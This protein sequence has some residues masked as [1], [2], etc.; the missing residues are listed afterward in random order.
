MTPDDRPK[1]FGIGLVSLDLVVSLQP[2]ALIRSWTGGTCGNILSI[3]AFL[4]WEAYPIARMNDDPASKRVRADLTRWGVRLDFSQCSP[5]S[6]TPIIVQEIQKRSDGSPTHRFHWVCQSCGRRL[7]RFRAVT[8]N[9]IEAVVPALGNASVFF[10]DRL[11]RSAITLAEIASNEGAV[12]VFE[13]SGATTAE[14]FLEALRIAHVVKY[15]EQ[16]ISN[17]P[18]ISENKNSNLVEIQT[19]GAKGLRYRH[20]FGPKVSKWMHLKALCVPNLVDSCGAG[21]W[22]TAGFIAKSSVN[23][24]F[25]L[26]KAGAMGIRNALKYGQ[27]LAAWNCGFEGARGGM[28]VVDRNTF[29]KQIEA[30]ATGQYDVP[31]PVV[32]DRTLDALVACPSCESENIRVAH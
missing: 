9:A 3:L 23:G 27:A 12:V 32:N 20:R 7:P 10:L 8:K 26:R 13:P 31:T 18:G 29:D 17:L 11:S 24:Q 5:T 21:D 1:I 2:F 22:C 14:L 19:S 15:A 4:D 30:L 25:G 28:Y 6:H 16:R